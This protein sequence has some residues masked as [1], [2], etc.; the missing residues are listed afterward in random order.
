MRPLIFS[1]FLA[2]P[3][4]PVA[5]IDKHEF[6]KD[7]YVDDNGKERRKF[8]CI[9]P[10]LIITKVIYTAM[11]ARRRAEEDAAFWDAFDGVERKLDEW[12]TA[13]VGRKKLQQEVKKRHRLAAREVQTWEERKR[14]TEARVCRPSFLFRAS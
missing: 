13:K 12:A 2:G 5:V 6:T 8:P 10:S 4:G 1:F 7:E 3:Y 11:E 14:G 9:V